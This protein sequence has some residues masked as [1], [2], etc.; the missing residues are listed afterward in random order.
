MNAINPWLE[1]KLLV[2]MSCLMFLASD[3][4]YSS[5]T[6]SDMDYPSN[7][8][9]LR[10]AQLETA[11]PEQRERQ[12]LRNFFQKI[13]DDQET[14]DDKAALT[15]VKSF[16]LHYPDMGDFEK[17]IKRTV[18]TRGV[19]CS[20]DLVIFYREV[21]GNYESWNTE[22][23]FGQPRPLYRYHKMVLDSALLIVNDLQQTRNKSV[24]YLKN[25]KREALEYLN[26][27]DHNFDKWEIEEYKKGFGN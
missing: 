20:G 13:P 17:D 11:Y 26:K 5:R 19:T 10:I 2:V 23:G 24:G 21:L 6:I 1:K 3:P 27:V 8:I 25:L 16:K 12:D 18:F 9:A 22:F 4:S 14:P 7:V 15:M